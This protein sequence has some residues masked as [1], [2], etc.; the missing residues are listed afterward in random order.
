[1]DSDK[2]YDMS[3]E[4]LQTK[5]IEKCV[6]YETESTMQDLIDLLEKYQNLLETFKGSFRYYDLQE[7]KKLLHTEKYGPFKNP[8]YPQS[9]PSKSKDR[10]KY[11]DHFVECYIAN[12]RT[13]RWRLRRIKEK[14]EKESLQLSRDLDS[15]ESKRKKDKYIA[16]VKKIELEIE[17][18]SESIK[19]QKLSCNG[20]F[21][22]LN[23]NYD[24]LIK[25]YQDLVKLKNE[26][27]KL[28]I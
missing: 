3:I 4:D 18:I 13:E 6:F 19:I 2:L 11:I 1:M 23:D 10:E 24:E 28:K 26:P 17:E 27:G 16:H 14:R 21:S 12:Y 15:A 5:A 9:D 7:L 20:D 25:L 22:K 8:N